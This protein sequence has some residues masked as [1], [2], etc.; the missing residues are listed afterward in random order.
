MIIQFLKCLDDGSD[1]NQRKQLSNQPLVR[2]NQIDIKRNEQH[3][4][5]TQKTDPKS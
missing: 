2:N 1:L 3:F 5:P 4:N